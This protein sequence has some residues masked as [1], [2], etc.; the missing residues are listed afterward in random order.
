[1]P[2]LIYFNNPHQFQ[3]K[4]ILGDIFADSQLGSLVEP[5]DFMVARKLF[6][7]RATPT[8]WILPKGST[9]EKKNV[10]IELEENFTVD[11]I[12]AKIATGRV[13]TLSTPK[14]SILANET[15]RISASMTDLEG[16]LI[17]IEPVT[18]W[19]N[20]SVISDINGVLDFSASAPG[21][22][23]I[24]TRNTDAV[25]GYLEVTVQ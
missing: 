8:L 20:G 3:S 7:F 14:T 22:Y 9:V 6:Y 1:M 18:F 5:M 19:I 25:Q 12:K 17:S 24:Q 15:I 21:V 11:D 2:R 16:N 23:V 10:A 13:I 4:K